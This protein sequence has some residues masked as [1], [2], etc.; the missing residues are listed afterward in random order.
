[1]IIVIQGELPHYRIGFFN[2]LSDLDEV[3]VVH[4]GMPVS[5]STDRFEEVVLPVKKL[6]PFQVQ[7]GLIELISERRPD[8]IIAMF[9]LRWVNSVRA[10]FRF[11]KALRWIWWGIG[12]GRNKF[13]SWARRVLAARPNPI[14]FY[15]EEARRSFSERQ[16][17]QSRL[18]VANNTLHV[19]DRIRCYQYPKKTR[20]INVGSLDER[21]QND[22]T[23]HVLKEIQDEIGA[24]ICFSLIG[25]GDASDSLQDLV[26]DLGMES[27]VE[28]IGRI[29][30]PALLS[31]YYK[32]AIAAVSFGQAGLAVLQSMAFGVPFVTRKN[33]ITGGEKYNIIDGVNGLLCGDNPDDLKEALLK[34]VQ[35]VDY[36]RTLGEAAFEHYT[37]TA[38]LDN[39]VSGFA[40]ALRWREEKHA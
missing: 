37:T 33:A 35:D 1:M 8:A 30:D 22:V 28:L 38:N 10:M 12:T 15:N 9:D 31:Q 20:L 36:A 17:L 29:V 13:A 21:K 6:G 2:A 40:E 16:D 27:N 39:M 4:S 32:E 23:I 25:D 26:K 34:L 14:V 18:F 19:P 5:C 7:Q 11:D 3:V 24:D